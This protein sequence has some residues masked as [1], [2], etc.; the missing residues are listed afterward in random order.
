MSN[1]KL[2]TTG[3]RFPEGP[4]WLP[5]GDVLVVEIE[6]GTLTR[7]SPDGTKTVVGDCKGG[8]NGAAMGPDGKVYIC[9]NGGF[10]WAEQ[11]GMLFPGN[12]PPDYIGGRIQTVDLNT[13]EVKSL[14]TEFEGVGLR[15]PNDIVFDKNGGFYFT[16]LGKGRPESVDRGAIYYGKPDG[17]P[18]VKVVGPLDH[19]N[20]ISLS[21]DDK[22]LYVCETITGRVWEWTLE[23]PG[24]VSQAGAMFA[25]PGGGRLTVSMPGYQLLDSMTVDSEGNLCLATLI[26]GCV[27]VV[28]PKGEILRQVKPPKEDP[29]VTNVCFGGADLKT[30]FITVS[31]NG[32]LWSC[33]WPVPGHKL[34]HY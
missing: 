5:N 20:G 18:L 1:W 33:D 11:D 30:A 12:Q 29:L 32:E 3:L 13:G 7:V 6:R 22:T 14:Y 9:N 34:A 8:P 23:S 24:V 15:G 21:P 31:A 2:I 16:D 10:I 17:S 19:P 27:T 28:S 25:A 4:I 26:T